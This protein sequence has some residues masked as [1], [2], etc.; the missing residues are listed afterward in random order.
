MISF[1]WLNFKVVLLLRTVNPLLSSLG[2]YVC[3]ARLRGVGGGGVGR[4]RLNSGGGL[5]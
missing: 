4:G 2:A 1:L 5:L 3:Q